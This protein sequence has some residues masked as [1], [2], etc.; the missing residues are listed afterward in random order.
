VKGSGSAWVGASREVAAGQG[1]GGTYT[2]FSPLGAKNHAAR[3]MATIITKPM[4][5][6]QLRRVRVSQADIWCWGG[7]RQLFPYPLAM[8]RDAD[9]VLC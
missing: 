4:M 5:T 1:E 2:W 3:H 7:L 8:L 9:G 6:L